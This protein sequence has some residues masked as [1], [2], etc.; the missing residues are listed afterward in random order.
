MTPPTRGRPRPGVVASPRCEPQSSLSVRQ[1]ASRH[2]APGDDPAKTQRPGERKAELE[3]K[4]ERE[5]KSERG[6]VERPP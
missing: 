4:A 2:G 5:G 1:G 6:L 3:G